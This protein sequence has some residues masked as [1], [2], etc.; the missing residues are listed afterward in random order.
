MYRFRRIEHLLD[1]YHE[2][3]KQEIYFA[4][5]EELNDPMEG[6]RDIFWKGDKIVWENLIANF[7][8]SLE[9][10]F[11]LLLLIGEGKKLDEDDVLVTF[12]TPRHETGQAIKIIREVVEKVFSYQEMAGFPKALEERTSLI[13]RDELLAYLQFIQ[14]IVLNSIT[15]VYSKNGLMTRA[16]YKPGPDSIQSSLKSVATTPGLLNGLEKENSN[17]PNAV[18]KF[19]HGVTFV[20]QQAILSTKIDMSEKYIT[21]NHFF[22]LSEFKEKYVKKLATLVYPDWYAASFMREYKNMAIWGHY[23]ENHTGVCLKFRSEQV[24]RKSLI[25]LET[26]NGS[27]ASREHPIPVPTFAKVSHEFRDIQYSSEPIEIDFFNSL[28]MIPVFEINGAWYSDQHG[29]RSLCGQDFQRDPESWRKKHWG[30]F[31]DGITIK[32]NEW[33]YEQESRLILAGGAIDFSAKNRRKLKYNFEDLDAII[34]GI[35][36]SAADKMRIIEIIKDKCKQNSRDE[37]EFYQAYYSVW[38][39][40]VEKYRMTI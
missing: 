3:E 7:I 5:P 27:R 26:E 11:H 17:I 33:A 18:D 21:S 15:D 37:F 16:I 20:S 34:F 35:R 39:K 31:Y 6:Y 24:E 4:S 23:G 36:T 32:T 38:T 9:H 29:N 40:T 1:K 30:N 28:A 25:K 10:F 12:H 22:L 13:R 2:L 8:K 19:F 14:P